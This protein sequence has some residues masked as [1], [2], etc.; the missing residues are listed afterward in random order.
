MLSSRAKDTI[1]RMT[2]SVVILVVLAA[3]VGST[4]GACALLVLTKKHRKI[5][6]ELFAIREQSRS[7]RADL[8]LVRKDLVQAT[9]RH[10][11]RLPLLL[12]SQNGEELLLW[13]FFDGKREGFFIEVGAFDGVTFSNTYFFEAIGWTGL[14]IEPIPEFFGECR[15]RRPFSRVVHAALSDGVIATDVLLN[16]AYGEKGEGLEALSFI[17]DNRY[18]LERIQ[19]ASG[20]VRTLTVPC[21]SLNELLVD[22]RGAIDFVIIDVEGAEIDVLRGFDLATYKPRV[23]VIEDN[24][25]GQDK[26]VGRWLQQCKYMERYRCEHN[27]FYTRHDDDRVFSWR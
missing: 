2:S 23:L 6:Q 1:E 12:P 22:H 9:I 18:Q 13:N 19:R 10:P 5:W 17:K 24:S 3:T 8:I 25:G 15:T 16:V 20:K 7:L 11:T 4:V 14:L 27:V 21:R 26:G